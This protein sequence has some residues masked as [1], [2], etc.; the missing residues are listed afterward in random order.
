MLPIR[1]S[2]VLAAAVAGVLALTGC[3]AN[4]PKASASTSTTSRSSDPSGAA[5]SSGPGRPNP[6]FLTKMQS[7]LKA[8][9]LEGALPTNLPT[10]RPSGAPTDLPSN[11]ATDLPSDGSLPSPPNGATPPSGA[12][13]GNGGAFAALA[14][15]EVQAALKACG[16][17]I[18]TRPQR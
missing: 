14:D 9:G 3:G 7:C 13:G 15:P 5:P 6:D 18:P 11:F 4:S 10:G 1:F 16:I 2:I 8:A 17:D 12:P